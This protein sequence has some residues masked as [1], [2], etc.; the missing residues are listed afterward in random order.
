MK[1]EKIKTA[2]FDVD[3]QCG[4]TPICPDELPVAGGDEIVEELNH[5]ARFATYRVA[6][7]EDHPSEAPW[8]TND[9]DTVMSPVPGE[10]PNL[11][12]MWPAHCIVGTL[13][14]QLLPGL[15]EEDAYDLLIRKGSDPEKHPYGSCYHDLAGAES[16]G[17]I[18]WLQQKGISTVIVGGLATD[19]CMKT[20]ALQLRQ[21]GFQV[22]VNLGACRSVNPATLEE[23][24]AEMHR[25][26]IEIIHSAAEL[27]TEG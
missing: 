10:H 12:V 3:P 15:P 8:I 27:E 24:C 9:P 26:G 4:F 13:G 11:D 20:T 2:S 23:D 19:F 17:V 22:V 25:V 7:K 16:T 5:Q 18:E 1:L 14:N 6:S 21:A